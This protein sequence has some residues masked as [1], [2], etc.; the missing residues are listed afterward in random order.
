MTDDN[1]TGKYPVGGNVG[2]LEEVCPVCGRCPRCGRRDPWYPAPWMPVDTY[3]NTHWTH[4]YDP[5]FVVT[6]IAE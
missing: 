4:E 5:N 3:P 6:W 2:P 1:T